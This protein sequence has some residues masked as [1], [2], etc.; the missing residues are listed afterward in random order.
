MAV[1]IEK[2]IAKYSSG[3][4]NREKNHKMKSKKPVTVTSS[5]Q[6]IYFLKKYIWGMVG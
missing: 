4:Q 1:R 2:R 5:G 6:L 3:F